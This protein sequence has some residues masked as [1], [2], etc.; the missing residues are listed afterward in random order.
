MLCGCN[1]MSKFGDLA[2]PTPR[3]ARG[4][5]GINHEC[6]IHLCSVSHHWQVCRVL[7]RR[8]A[9]INHECG[10][11]LCSESQHCAARLYSLAPPNTSMQAERLR[12]RMLMLVLVLVLMLMTIPDRLPPP[13]AS[14]HRSDGRRGSQDYG[15]YDSLWWASRCTVQPWP[16][17][18]VASPCRDR[19]RLRSMLW[20]PSI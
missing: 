7:A 19:P 11:H 6:G 15:R 20:G 10:V 8:F 2:P 9:G 13:A 12:M 18:L 17:P 5:A 4:F 14:C 3:A 16:R 1:A